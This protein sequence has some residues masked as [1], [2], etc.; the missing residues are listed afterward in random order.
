M[1]TISHDTRPPGE[2]RRKG[3]MPR[4]FMGLTEAGGY[5][6]SL[7]DGL[8]RIGAANVFVDLTANKFQYGANRRAGVFLWLYRRVRSRMGRG[9]GRAGKF[10]AGAEWLLRLLL[11]VWAVI[12]YDVFVFAYFSTFFNFREL[13]V[14]RF[15]RKKIVF[16]FLGTDC[17]PPYVNGK[18]VVETSHDGVF[19]L[20][21]R[22]KQWMTTVEK[23]AHIIVNHPP[24][25][26][27]QT[28]PFVSHLVLGF[29][30]DARRVPKAPPRSENGP[31]RVVHAPSAP[32]I[33]GTFLIRKVID[34]LKARG[35]AIEYV[36]LINRPNAQVIEELSRC[37]LVVD[38]LF[39][40]IP[41]GGLGTE[42]AFA[43]K[44]VVTA[45]YYADQIAKDYPG[46]YIAPTFFCKPEVIGPIIE[47]L[48]LDRDLRLRVGDALRRFVEARSA[49]EK[50][51]ERYVQMV[52]DGVPADWTFDPN[53]IEYLTG[54]GLPLKAHKDFL[55]AYLAKFGPAGLQ[56]DDKPHLVKQFMEY[57]GVATN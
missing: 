40:D 55:K 26:L 5:M 23:Y 18:V 12:R 4:F 21:R 45:G 56:L 22:K 15:L 10:W 33:K 39:S 29:P 2:K 37:D 3:R 51:A 54:Y 49:A 46:A 42:G 13:P 16:V 11:L 43:G 30:F 47:R 38:E 57:A 25:A 34:A 28:R 48:V 24:M 52:R 14:L 27:F 31:V 32:V 8:T 9:A 17:R 41:L 36:E 35:H 50:V 7:S 20:A 6:N 19:A 44:P 53:K 1:T